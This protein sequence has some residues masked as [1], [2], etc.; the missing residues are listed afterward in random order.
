MD[1]ANNQGSLNYSYYFQICANID[2]LASPMFPYPGTACNW[3]CNGWGQNNCDPSNY[4]LGP[5]PA[6]QVNNLIAPTKPNDPDACH[7]LGTT[8]STAAQ[9][10]YGLYDA[11]N[12]SRGLTMT[13]VGGDVCVLG[14]NRI[15][16]QLKLWMLCDPD[17]P[18]RLPS[19]ELVIEAPGSC[20]Y[21]IFLRTTFA[22]PAQCPVI[23]SK[24]CN[25]HGFCEFDPVAANSR[26]F[27]NDGYGGV[28]CSAQGAASTGLS[29]I[30]VGLICLGLFLTAT[31]GFLVYLWSRIRSL[32]LDTS[33][34]RSL[35]MG[36]E[37]SGPAPSTQSTAIE[38]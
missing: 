21:E 26:C 25:G 12:P 7:R 4:V 16:R 27:C 19:T 17:A 8:I 22:C 23:N 3:T 32:R 30:G 34:Y 20:L 14:A 38:Q 9:I 31:L 5:A 18:N 6:F 28:D 24:L 11:T 29:A 37:D 2:P 10:Q 35:A 1:A 13:Y 36:P 33:A 15:P